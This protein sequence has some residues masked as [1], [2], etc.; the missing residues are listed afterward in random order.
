MTT[1]GYERH[2]RRVRRTY[3]EVVAERMSDSIARHFPADTRVTRPQGGQV[4]WVDDPEQGLMS[5]PGSP[6]ALLYIR[7]KEM[8]G[9]MTCN[10]QHDILMHQFTAPPPSHP[11]PRT[12]RACPTIAV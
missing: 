1:G 10:A 3:A 9:V 12:P 7:H 4:L 11:C 6:I 5:L 8:V 2:L